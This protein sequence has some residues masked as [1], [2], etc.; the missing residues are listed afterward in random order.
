MR[1]PRKLLAL[2]LVVL[3]LAI[4][5]V[6]WLGLRPDGPTDFAGGARIELADYRGS[7]PTGAPPSIAGTDMVARGEYLTRA[8]DCVACHTAPGGKPFAGGLAFPLPFGSLYSTNITPDKDIGIGVWSDENFVRALHEG[9]GRDGKH[10]YPAFPYTSYTLMTRSDVLAIKAYLFS[11]KPVRNRPPA[12]DISFPF[13][14][15]YL[16]W[17]WNRLFSPGQRFQPNTGQ[18]PEWNRGA[19]LLEALGH[20][21]ECHTPRNLLYGL[22]SGRKFAGTMINGWKAYNIASDPAWG[23][24]GLR[25]AVGGLFV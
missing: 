24:G 4:G 5:A 16:I 21:G 9:V 15:R 12:N 1:L 23:I 18:T 22:S 10:L 7:D 2:A 19:Y 25:R 11:L 3:V 8:A 13:N 20:C 14:Q 6:G 17:F